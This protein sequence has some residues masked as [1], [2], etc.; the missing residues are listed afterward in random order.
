MCEYGIKQFINGRSGFFICLVPGKLGS[1][2]L[3]RD[4]SNK[5]IM[6]KDPTSSESESINSTSMGKG[7]LHKVYIWKKSKLAGEFRVNSTNLKERQKTVKLLFL[8]S[9]IEAHSNCVQHST[10]QTNPEKIIRHIY[11]ATESR[12][13]ATLG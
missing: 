12:P 6:L 11:W 8:A 3:D 1:H 10:N 9:T 2:G 4:V 13:W 7:P 5:P